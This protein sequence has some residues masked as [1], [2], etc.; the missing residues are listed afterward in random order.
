VRLRYGSNDGEA[1]ARARSIPE[2]G[3]LGPCEGL[4]GAIQEVRR[5]AWSRVLHADRQ[6]PVPSNRSKL[7]HSARSGVTKGIVQQ[8]LNGL[9]KPRGIDPGDFAFAP[10]L[11]FDPNA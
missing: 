5:E 1:Q 6:E 9:P 4:E 11:E 10:Y 7:D 8:V 2:H 3:G